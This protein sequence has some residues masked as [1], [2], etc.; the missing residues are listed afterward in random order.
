MGGEGTYFEGE[1]KR[2]Q[3]EEKRER[4]RGKGRKGLALPLFWSFRRL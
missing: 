4:E 3:R 1:G 2:R